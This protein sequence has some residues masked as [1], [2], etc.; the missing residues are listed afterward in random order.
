MGSLLKIKSVSLY[1]MT[2][3]YIIVGTKPTIYSYVEECFI[4]VADLFENPE[5]YYENG[6]HDNTDFDALLN[7]YTERQVASACL[8]YLKSLAKDKDE[9]M[10]IWNKTFIEL[11]CDGEIAFDQLIQLIEAG[12][13]TGSN[14]LREIEKKAKRKGCSIKKG[15]RYG[16]ND[17]YYGVHHISYLIDKYFPC[18]YERGVDYCDNCGNCF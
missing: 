6:Y 13:I 12:E 5:K 4:M 9:K 3:Q 7:D 15:Y 14:Q 16:E 18:Y 1:T 11:D 2:Y 10:I 17:I 8:K